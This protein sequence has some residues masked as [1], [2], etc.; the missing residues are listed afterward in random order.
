LESRGVTFKSGRGGHL[1]AYLGNRRS[2]VPMHAGD[3]KTGLMKA[4]L[5]QLGIDEKEIS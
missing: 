3:L 5:K 1:K 4:I 2:V